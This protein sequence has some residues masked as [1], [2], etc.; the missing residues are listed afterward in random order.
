MKRR[1]EML[2]AH[3]ETVLPEGADPAERDSQFVTALARGLDVLRAFRPGDGPL[4]NQQ[5]AERTGLPKP[6]VSRLTYTLSRL[7]YLEHL[8]D[9]GKYALGVGV[10]SLGFTALGAMGMRRIA[11]PFLQELATYSGLSVALGTRDQ[12]SMVYLECCRGDSAIMLALDVG[13]HLKLSTSAI[14]RAYL[15][16]LP[17]AEQAG[18]FASLARHEG[19]R[20]P[21]A[22]RGLEQAKTDI[23]NR[24]FC[25]SAGDWKSEV[26]AVGVPLGVGEGGLAFALNCGGPAYMLPFER[27]IDDI[28]PRLVQ[29]AAAIRRQMGME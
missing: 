9:V 8:S 2:E 14:G 12:L 5:L 27:L 11:R 24:G 29:V 15:S 13:S 4:G 22:L 28:G 18:L 10:L 3:T 1:G 23:A 26:N 19:D 21:E 7:G 17:P 16:A 20:W 25:L 6:T